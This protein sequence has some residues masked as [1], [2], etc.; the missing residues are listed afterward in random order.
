MV[1]H[2]HLF[3]F[4]QLHRK[5]PWRVLQTGD[6]LAGKKDDSFALLWRTKQQIEQVTRFDMKSLLTD[7]SFFFAALANSD[8]SRLLWR[9]SSE[10]IISLLQNHKPHTDRRSRTT[11]SLISYPSKEGS[12]GGMRSVKHKAKASKRTFFFYLWITGFLFFY[13]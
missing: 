1:F 10:L 7:C 9:E 13:E 12:G 4:C 3:L 8:R 5:R 11:Y 6:Y 2:L